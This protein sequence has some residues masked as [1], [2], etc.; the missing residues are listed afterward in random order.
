LYIC[1][2]KF[3]CT[4]YILCMYRVHTKPILHM[5][6]FVDYCVMKT[7]RRGVLCLWFKYL[8]NG[9]ENLLIVGTMGNLLDEVDV[10]VLWALSAEIP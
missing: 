4:E 6:A 10:T 9:Q 3:V 7:Y 5:Q 2:T 8:K 1:G